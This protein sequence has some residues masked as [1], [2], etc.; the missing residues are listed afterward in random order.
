MS[1]R[2]TNDK[3]LQ[4]SDVEAEIVD[5]LLRRYGLV[6]VR[7]PDAAPITASFWGEP[8]AGIPTV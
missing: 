3:V 5:Q 6:A 2:E 4:V 1:Q 7:V 8:E